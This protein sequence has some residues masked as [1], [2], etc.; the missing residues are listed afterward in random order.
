MSSALIIKVSW[1]AV[2]FEEQASGLLQNCGIIQVERDWRD[3]P[4]AAFCLN[5]SYDVGQGCT[6]LYPVWSQKPPSLDRECVNSV[7]VLEFPKDCGGSPCLAAT[8]PPSHSLTPLSQQERGRK[9]DGKNSWVKTGTGSLLTNYLHRQN[10]LN[11][12]KI[13]LLPIEIDLASEKQRKN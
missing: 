9:Q 8:C 2:C 7:S 10:R 6:G 5:L 12:G 4:G 1:L 11:L 3:S 13:S